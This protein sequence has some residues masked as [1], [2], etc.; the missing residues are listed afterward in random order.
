MTIIAEMKGHSTLIHLF[1]QGIW[2]NELPTFHEDK[3]L[4]QCIRSR[5]VRYN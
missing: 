2:Q 4:L 5:R 1:N 3:Y